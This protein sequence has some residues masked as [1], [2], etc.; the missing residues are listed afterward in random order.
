MFEDCYGLTTAPELPATTLAEGCY[1][2]MFED[3][4]GLTTAPELPA[5]T[6]AE[7]CYRFL[8][9][10]CSSLTIAPELPATTLVDNCYFRMF[11]GCTNLNYIKALFRTTPDDT[12]T[13]EWV[14]GVASTGTFVKSKDATWDVTGVNGVPEGWTI[15][16][17][18]TVEAVDLGIMMT[19]EDG[20]TYK[21]Y[22]AKSNLSTSG[23]CANPEDYGAYYA[24]GE[25]E[26][27]IDSWAYNWFNYKWCNGSYN[28]LTKYN[29]D[30]SYG[31]V[32]N[33]TELQRCEK[34]GETMD[35]AARAKLGGKWRMPTD[36]EWTA[37]REQCTW[38]W[39]TQNGTNGRLVTAP[40]GNSI[41]LPAAG[42]GHGN[43]FL[44]VGSDGYYWSSSLNTDD[45]DRA[46]NVYFDSGDVGR[47][48][49]TRYYGFSVRPV[50]E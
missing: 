36:A 25:T 38:T 20:T 37:L 30:S 39:T 8:F 10:G 48:Y 15:F 29:N 12:Y 18:A 42:Y 35:D 6:L 47:Y 45:P 31:T 16:T 22:W 43:N 11:N 2:G 17:D 4:Y 28:T 24:W 7:G 40:N 9:H 34:A 33:I 3:C 41:F 14:K 19:R 49:Y 13:G 32:D 46:W 26:K 27:A 21:L 50:S 44:G 1:S 5:T 23:L